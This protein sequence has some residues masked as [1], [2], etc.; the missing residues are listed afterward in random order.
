MWHKPLQQLLFLP[1]KSINDT[2]FFLI[3]ALLVIFKNKPVTVLFAMWFI[4]HFVTWQKKT[5]TTKL[6]NV[7]FLCISHFLLFRLNAANYCLIR[8]TVSRSI[9]KSQWLEINTKWHGFSQ[10]LMLVLAQNV[11]PAKNQYFQQVSDTDKALTAA[12]S[13]SGQLEAKSVATTSQN[14]FNNF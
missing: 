10:K 4:W 12:D 13:F 7:F 6:L 11:K 5:L 14:F 2:V 8:Y 9:H 3:C 1:F